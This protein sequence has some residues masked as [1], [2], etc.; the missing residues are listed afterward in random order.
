M[1]DD[2]FEK[3]EPSLA[4]DRGFPPTFFIHGDAD[5]MIPNSLSE[6]AF[7][8]L[9]SRA[10][11]S[12]LCLVPNQNHGFDAGLSPEDE[13]WPYVRKGLDFLIREGNTAMA[14]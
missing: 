2:N 9:S 6:R 12:E 11:K 10:V 13:E 7:A 5:S 1:Q 4:F 3:V 8:D 14:S